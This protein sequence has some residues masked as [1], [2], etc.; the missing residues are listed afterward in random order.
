MRHAYV[1]DLVKLW[2]A[3]SGALR[4]ELEALERGEEILCPRC[5]QVI[6]PDQAWDLGHDD[7]VP[8]FE[9]PEHRHCNRAAPNRLITSR[10]W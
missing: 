2:P 9:R 3:R 10:Q 5:D 7:Y 4:L 6:G 1:F 8:E